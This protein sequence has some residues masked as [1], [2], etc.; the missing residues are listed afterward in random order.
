MDVVPKVIVG[1]NGSS[2]GQGSSVMEALLTM[3]L[4]DKMLGSVASM[5]PP[6]QDPKVAAVREKLVAS[7]ENGRS[8]A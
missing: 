1:G 4:S 6:A 2:N 7:L 3:M 5:T 8:H